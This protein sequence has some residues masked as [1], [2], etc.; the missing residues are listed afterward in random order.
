MKNDQSNFA[1][2]IDKCVQWTSANNMKLNPKTKELRVW[3]STQWAYQGITIN[4]KPVEV[5]KH[6]KLSALPSADCYCLS[7]VRIR[8]VLEYACEVWHG[9]L[10]SYLRDQ[11]E[12][13]QNGALRI[14]SPI[15]AMLRAM[16]AATTST[17]EPK[18]VTAFVL[19]YFITWQALATRSTV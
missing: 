1:L 13:I 3:F 7:Y 5:V 17:L 10:Q 14:I 18:D 6:A 4:D 11:L 2:T 9:S 16:N 8:R 19:V 12:A 15:S